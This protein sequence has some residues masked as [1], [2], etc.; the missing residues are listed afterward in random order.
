M[1]AEGF[2]HH[3]IKSLRKR[4]KLSDFAL[5]VVWICGIIGVSAAISKT[6]QSGEPE[7]LTF[8]MSVIAVIASIPV[9]TERQKISR[10][11]KSKNQ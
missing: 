1:V 10:V 7:I 5:M 3:N 6:L 9:F 11:L 8:L 4:K 2:E